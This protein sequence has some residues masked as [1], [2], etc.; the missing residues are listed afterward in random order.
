MTV[1]AP[2]DRP[3]SV[4]NN[5]VIGRICSVFVSFLLCIVCH[6]GV[7]V[8]RLRQ[9]SPLFSLYPYLFP[10]AVWS[11]CNKVPRV[12]MSKVSLFNSSGLYVDSITKGSSRRQKVLYLAPLQLCTYSSLSIALW[13]TRR[14][15]LHDRPC[16]NSRRDDKLFPFWLLVGTPTALRPTLVYENCAE[17][18]LLLRMSLDICDVIITTNISVFKFSWPLRLRWMF[19]LGFYMEVYY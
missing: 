8:I 9:I 17:H 5:C 6:L 18:S 4:R 3:K 2:A 10:A 13:L 7:Y 15:G 14:W 12:W 1:V 11:V 16:P 19:V